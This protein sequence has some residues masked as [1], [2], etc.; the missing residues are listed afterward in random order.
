[1]IE[2]YVMYKLRMEPDP[3]AAQDDLALAQRAIHEKRIAE[4]L[5]LR[6]L[7]KLRRAVRIMAKNHQ[8]TDDLLNKTLLAVFESFGSFKGTGSLEAWAGRIAF[9][10]VVRHKQRNRMVSAVMVSA[11]P[12]GAVASS[13]PEREAETLQLREKLTTALRELPAER[14]NALVLR[15]MFGHSIEEIAHL[16]GA[17][18]NTVRGRLRVGLKEIRRDL[19]GQRDFLVAR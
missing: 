9:N 13:N 10:T 3:K 11:D 16:T 8:E 14:R 5:L 17:P 4:D 6:L 2:V 1:L 18:V 15:L 12:S 7:P 19:A